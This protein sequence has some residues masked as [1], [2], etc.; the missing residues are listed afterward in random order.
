MATFAAGFDPALLSAAL[1]GRCTR[2]RAGLFG[3]VRGGLPGR[4][5]ALPTALPDR[6]R[7]LDRHDGGLSPALPG[8]E[9]RHE[10]RHQRLSTTLPASVHSR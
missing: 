7:V 8:R 3:A 9:R 5:H 2:G 4:G 10:Q 6:E 1:R